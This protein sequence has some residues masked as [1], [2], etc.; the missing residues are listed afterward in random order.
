MA[1]FSYESDIAPMR[2]SYFYNDPSIS[3]EELSQL[4]AGYNRKIAPIEESILKS[5]DSMLKDQASQMAFERQKMDLEKSR[6]EAR[7]Q[8]EAS[9]RLG[10]LTNSLGTIVNDKSKDVFGRAA[11]LA[12]LKMSVSNLVA[13]DPTTRAVFDAAASKLSVDEELLKREE[14]IKNNR[15]DLMSRA[16]ALGDVDLINRLASSTTE[17][18][19]RQYL[20][21]AA[22]YA[23][24]NKAKSQAESDKEQ[25]AAQA[26]DE[27]ARQ[28]V[29]LS[30]L[31]SYE[32]TLNGM[33]QQKEDA[34]AV[35][36]SL[37][38]G[39]ALPTTGPKPLNFKAEDG[40]LLDSILLDLHP[41]LNRNPKQ[42]DTTPT[43]TKYRT[44]LQLIRQKKAALG[45]KPT[46]TIPSL[47]NK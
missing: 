25:R 31:N 17:P 16:T 21:I 41:D 27:K 39:T 28:S 44:A 23:A 14:K 47:F 12:T 4:Q 43:E 11:D 8:I 3:T 35:P 2:G 1:D 5:A 45:P 18:D 22:S 15:L 34:E 19:E 46:S 7:M 42:L 26:A 40:I 6:D 29:Y 9:N 30:T 32:S 37:K 13:R 33:G 36:T 20:E 10:E 38:T 24:S